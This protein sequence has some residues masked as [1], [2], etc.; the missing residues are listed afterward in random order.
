M[1]ITIS[2]GILTAIINPK[3]AELNSLKDGNS[4]YMWEGDANLLIS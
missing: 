3:G 1:D 4:E 2:N